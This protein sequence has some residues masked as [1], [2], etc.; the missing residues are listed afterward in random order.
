MSERISLTQQHSLVHT[1][2][3]RSNTASLSVCSCV[4][5]GGM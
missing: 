5:L 4:G 3:R 1:Q 2:G